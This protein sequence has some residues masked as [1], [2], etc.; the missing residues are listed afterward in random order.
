MIRWTGEKPLKEY[1]FENSTHRETVKHRK[2]DKNDSEIKLTSY[3]LGKNSG[4]FSDEIEPTSAYSPY[5]E[6]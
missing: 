4:D 1:E 6:N 5:N 3:S 2:V